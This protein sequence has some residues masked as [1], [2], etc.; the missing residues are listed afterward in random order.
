MALINLRGIQVSF[1]GPSLLDGIDL[2]IDKGERICLLGRN[3][4]G[5]STLMK[6]ILGELQADD[7]ERVVNAGVRIA[8]LIQEVPAGTQ[9]S[10]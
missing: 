6:L 9:G 8:R 1:G 4:A 3:G 10:V 2:S 7:G 5:K